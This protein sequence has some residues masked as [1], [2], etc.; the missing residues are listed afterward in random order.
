MHLPNDWSNASAG[1]Y[2]PQRI[3]IVRAGMHNKD[4]QGVRGNLG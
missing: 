2:A 4:L 1:M 3:V